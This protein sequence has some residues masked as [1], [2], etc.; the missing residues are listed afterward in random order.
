WKGVPHLQNTRRGDSPS[1]IKRRPLSF[2]KGRVRRATRAPY[3]SQG[4]HGLTPEPIYKLTDHWPSANS[5]AFGLQPA[6]QP[7]AF[8]LQPSASAFGPQP[9]AFSLQPMCNVYGLLS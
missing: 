6:L 9:S 4:P 3:G 5:S 2:K 8:G 7:L 1:I